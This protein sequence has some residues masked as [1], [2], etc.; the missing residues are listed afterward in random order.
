MLIKFRGNTYDTEFN[1]EMEKLQEVLRKV[2][3]EVDSKKQLAALFKP[4]DPYFA[5]TD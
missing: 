4:K 1:S 5:G 3:G 2:E